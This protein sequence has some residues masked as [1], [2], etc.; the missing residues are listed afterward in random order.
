[1]KI[2]TADHLRKL[3][4][5]KPAIDW[6]VDTYGENGSVP[7]DEGMEACPVEMWVSWFR[8][9]DTSLDADDRRILYDKVRKPK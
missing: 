6:F 9:K 1:M 4:A 7:L 8:K 2:V 5:C 3:R